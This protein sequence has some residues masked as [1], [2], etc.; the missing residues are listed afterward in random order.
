M[1]PVDTNALGAMEVRMPPPE[2]SDT[3]E[4]NGPTLWV[5]ELEG[6]DPDPKVNGTL[7]DIDPRVR[8]TLEL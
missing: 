1:P 2:V 4:E 7:D 6:S 3:L 8:G 5:N